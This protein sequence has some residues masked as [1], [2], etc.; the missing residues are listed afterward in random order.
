[1]RT[2]LF[3]NGLS[4]TY[5]AE[6]YRLETL[7]ELV[8][9]RLGGTDAGGGKSLLNE[10]DTVAKALGPG[11]GKNNDFEKLAGP[12]DTLAKSFVQLSR[13]QSIAGDRDTRIALY[14]MSTRLRK[15]HS[16]VVGMVLDLVAGTLPDGDW[17]PMNKVADHLFEAAG[18]EGELDVFTLNYDALLDCALLDARSR[19]RSVSLMDEFDGRK[20]G[21]EIRIPGK[22]KFI[23]TNTW[24]FDPYTPPHAPLRLHHLHGAATWLEQGPN[25]YKAELKSLRDF[26]VFDR[27]ESGNQIGVS[28]AVVLTD[29]KERVVGRWP[30]VESYERLTAA[31][32]GSSQLVI[33]GYSFRD[34]PLNR[35]LVGSLNSD[36][37][38]LAIVRS[39]RSKRLALNVL[40]RSQ[41]K[42]TIVEGSLPSVLEVLT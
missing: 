6:H 2:Y 26:G 11:L 5:N 10:V 9:V 1:M 30:F 37:E 16:Q 33:A 19:H 41:G 13:L 32:A 40:N 25:V 22:N 42:I 7:S 34:R 39:D 8:R 36:C 31:V 20:E 28:P 24:R 21:L 3:G 23:L 18:W 15:L 29:Q 14:R 35:V 38:V 12:I 17:T 4:L 27:W